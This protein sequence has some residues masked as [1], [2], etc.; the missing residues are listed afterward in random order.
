[1]TLLRALTRPEEVEEPVFVPLSTLTEG[2]DAGGDAA[3]AWGLGAA[4]AANELEL[5]GGADG[6]ETEVVETEVEEG[7]GSGTTTHS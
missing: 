3:A 7:A 6:G 5:V 2:A 4:C 1:M